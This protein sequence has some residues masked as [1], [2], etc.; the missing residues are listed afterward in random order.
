MI[1]VKMFDGCN[2]VSTSCRN[3]FFSEG[4]E[5]IKLDS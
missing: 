4:N 2:V 1:L 5:C 3:V